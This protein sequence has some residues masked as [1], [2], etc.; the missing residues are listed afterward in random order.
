MVDIRSFNNPISSHK[1]KW[2]AERL[3]GEVYEDWDALLRSVRKG[4]VVE[5]VELFLL[6]PATGRP[7]KRRDTLLDRIDAIKDKGGTLLE[8]ST[9]FT[10]T[11]QNQYNRML[12]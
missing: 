4:S 3:T 2:Q 11:N 5:V 9:K 6:A 7:S 1:R 12:M 10:S 8:A